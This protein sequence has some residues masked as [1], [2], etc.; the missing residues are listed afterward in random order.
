MDSIDRHSHWQDPE[1]LKSVV[2]IKRE[3]SQKPIEIKLERGWIRITEHE[4]FLAIGRVTTIQTYT[5]RE[6][7]AI[8]EAIRQ[9]TEEK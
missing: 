5:K 8:A 3:S 9:L 4:D 1:R 2:I 6:A 7:M